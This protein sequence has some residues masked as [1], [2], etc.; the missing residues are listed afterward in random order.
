M[1]HPTTPASPPQCSGRHGPSMP[2]DCAPA[3]PPTPEEPTPMSAKFIQIAV[4]DDSIY[5]LDADGVVWWYDQRKEPAW[6]ACK[7]SRAATPVPPEGTLDEQASED[8][9]VATSIRRMANDPV[10]CTS[11]IAGGSHPSGMT[12]EL[13]CGE[14]GPC[15]RQAFA[16]DVLD[17]IAALTRGTRT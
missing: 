14:C 5:A 11:P 9:R 3:S 16:Q 6:S 7:T 13:C 10:E 17:T 1:I 2:C 4:D 12:E 15:Q 8:R